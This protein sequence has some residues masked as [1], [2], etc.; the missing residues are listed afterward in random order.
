MANERDG[1]ARVISQD[2]ERLQVDHKGARLTVGM[3]GFPPKFTLRPGSRVVLFDEPSGPVARPLVRAI[4]ARVAKDEIE[5]RGRIDASGRNLEMQQSTIVED[6]PPQ[7]RERPSG[8]DEIW[9]VDSVGEQ[10][11]DQVVAVRRRR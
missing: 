2:G 10:G 7:A 5:A 3:R 8:E 4:R 9:V 6:A 1:A 11:P